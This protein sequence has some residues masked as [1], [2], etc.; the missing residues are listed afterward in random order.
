MKAK[1]LIITSETDPSKDKLRVGLLEKCSGNDGIHARYL[2]ESA[3]ELHTTFN[4]VMC[5]NDITGVDDD[6]GATLRRL[7]LA[8]FVKKAVENPLG[9][10]QIKMKKN[11]PTQIL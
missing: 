6:S 7:I 10:N 9:P 5:F 2:Y 11:P 4:I 3:S 8:R 1:R